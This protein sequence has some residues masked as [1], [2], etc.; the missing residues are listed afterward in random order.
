MRAVR[1]GPRD[2]DP[3]RRRRRAPP[4]G[5]RRADRPR[6]PRSRVALVPVTLTSI[7]PALPTRDGQITLPA[8][9]HQHHQ[10]ATRPSAGLLLA[11]PG[12][13]HRSGGL[14]PGA[15]LRVQRPDRPSGGRSATR[16]CTSET[17]PYLDPGRDPPLHADRPGRAARAVSHRRRLPDGR[18]RPPGT[19]RYPPSVG[20]GCSCPVVATPPTEQLRM[21]SLVTFTSRPSLVRTGVLGR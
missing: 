7:N 17:D 11:Q 18:A 1:S 6:T 3:R 21:T 8:R 14:R 2:C 10:R 12:P 13:D 4:R 20:P 19:T 5:R 15:R 16:T 9:R